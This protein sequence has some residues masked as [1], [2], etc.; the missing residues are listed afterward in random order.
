MAPFSSIDMAGGRESHHWHVL[1]T[2]RTKDL[3]KPYGMDVEKAFHCIDH[4]ISMLEYFPPPSFQGQ[5]ASRAEWEMFQL[6]KTPRE[7]VQ[8]D[9]KLRLLPC[10]YQEKL[11]GLEQDYQRM[12]DIKFLSN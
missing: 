7:D 3:I 6:T 4:L 11:T 8:R 9:I 1:S 5:P 12:P 10:G 2:A